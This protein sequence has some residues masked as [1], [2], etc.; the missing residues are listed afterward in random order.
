MIA[1]SSV[2]SQICLTNAWQYFTQNNIAKANK[3]LTECGTSDDILANPEYWLTKGN[4]YLK[5]ADNASYREKYPD[6]ILTAYEAFYK[7]IE[8][9]EY[10][11][12]TKSKM[13]S[14]IQGQSFC[15]RELFNKGYTYY[16]A[17][18]FTNAVKYLECASKSFSLDKTNNAAKQNM[19]TSNFLIALCAEKLGNTDLYKKTLEKS[20][21]AHTDRTDVYA[22]LIEVYQN[23]KD[24]AKVLKTIA[25][26]L[27]NY[28]NDQMLMMEEL[29]ILFWAQKTTEL[30]QKIDAVMA[31][32]ADS[33][34]VMALLGNILVLSKQFDKAETLLLKSIEKWPEDFNIN[35]ATGQSF[36]L[37]AEEID[38]ERT[39]V[40]NAGR[41]KEV[42][43]ITEK[44]DATY[45]KALPYLEKAYKLN[46]NDNL[47]FIMYYQTLVLLKKPTDN[48]LKEKYESLLKK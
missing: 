39:T 45:E 6:A 32:Y 30:N 11:D 23:E 36:Y 8:L 34:Q 47:N 41:Y 10:N 12:V 22:M 42:S 7:A 21:A 2:F 1:T 35:K 28:P 16:E 19:H 40:I 4:I 20:V 44:R 3:A 9:N 17:G 27:Q 29:K 5:F 43:A 33:S 48:S 15:G 26:A 37:M 46:A 18:D 31:T 24:T 25:T 14:A 13:L 38:K